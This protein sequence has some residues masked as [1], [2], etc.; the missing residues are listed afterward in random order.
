MGRLSAYLLLS[1]ALRHRP[2]TPRRPHTVSSVL[3]TAPP[4]IVSDVSR[5]LYLIPTGA[6]PFPFLLFAAF[7]FPSPKRPL[8]RIFLPNTRPRPSVHLQY[9]S[10]PVATL[11]ICSD[12]LIL[13]LNRP[14]RRVALSN[15]TPPHIPQSLRVFCSTRRP[16]IT[17]RPLSFTISS[18]SL[19]SS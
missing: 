10:A 14:Y 16:H 5:A 1:H 17:L 9:P 8:F 13:Y 4:S 3:C 7:A 6:P 18:F 12:E 19:S 11:T 15:N 2:P